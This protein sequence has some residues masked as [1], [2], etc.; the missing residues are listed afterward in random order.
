MEGDLAIFNELVTVLTLINTVIL[1]SLVIVLYI[2]KRSIPDIQQVLD[3][4]GASVGEQFSGIFEK[5][6]VSKAMSVLGQKSGEVRADKALRKKAANALIQQIPAAGFVL[7]QLGMT[8]EEGLRLMNDP[9]IG[10]LIQNMLQKGTGGIQN[11]LGGL[12][13]GG[14]SPS[15]PPSRNNGDVFKVT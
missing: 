15:S 8:A 13:G 10:P 4:V 14:G 12:G 2:F 6:A 7:D 9:M 1:A 5:P 3:D 11:L